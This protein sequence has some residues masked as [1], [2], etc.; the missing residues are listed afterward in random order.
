MNAERLKA[1]CETKR[2]AG[3]RLDVKKFSETVDY[4]EFSGVATTP[5]QDLVGDIVDPLGAE[6][7]LPVTLLSKHDAHKPIGE[8]YFAR[9][10]KEGIPYRARIPKVT[11]EGLVKQRIEEA[12]HEVK[13]GLVKNVS[14]GFKAIHE[15]VEA[16]KNGGLHF[17]RWKWLELSLAPIPANDEATILAFKSLN[18]KIRAALGTSE[19]S[20]EQLADPSRAREQRSK[21]T[22]MRGI[23]ELSARRDEVAGR[24]KDLLDACGGERAELEATEVAELDECKKEL[25]DLDVAIDDQR[26][27][28]RATKGGGAAPVSTVRDQDAGSRSRQGV[29]REAKK[30]EDPARKGIAFAQYVRVMYHAK[31]SPILAQQLVKSPKW[32]R[33]LDDRVP[34]LIKAAVEA[35][36]VTGT[37]SDGN[38]GME[39]VGDETGAVA[40]FAEFL[41]KQTLLG[42]FGTNGIPA[43]RRVPFRVPLLTQGTGA[44]AS[45]VG[46]GKPK[47]LTKLG[48]SRTTL[49][50]RKIA[51]IA[52]VTKE[53]LAD[54]SPA[55][56]T[57]LRDELAAAVVERSDIDFIDPSVTETTDVRPAAITQGITPVEATGTG[58]AD[59]VRADIR[60][61]LGAFMTAK[62]P[63]RS[64]VWIMNSAQAIA[65]GLMT[66][67]LG[68]MEFPGVDMNGGRLLGI[69]VLVTDHMPTT[70]SGHY[71]VLLNTTDV[72][73]NDDGGVTIDTSEHASLEMDDAPT[74]DSVTPT[75]TTLVSM[76]QT[77]S[78]AFRA[79]RRLNY[80]R[81]RDSGVYVI[82][83]ANWGEA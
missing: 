1:L 4:F 76:F 20:V 12:I 51:V 48:W 5:K 33:S 75:E 11:E 56:D 24:V 34:R 67:A 65:L 81:R 32:A 68:Q 8:V 49:E 29:A 58:D 22:N 7:S 74:H 38:W 78:V 42:K 66:N 72:Y 39:L 45:W 50:P 63:P 62:N 80:K 2:S 10:T 21:G 36:S 17:K 57:M 47:P 53:L 64:A 79:E 30:D 19:K 23:Q 18:T 69:P 54:S 25:G 16:L 14:I 52:A 83:N 37:G 73:F 13:Y 3:V 26:A 44:T 61:A 82:A 70:T 6:F 71:I 28:E 46:E 35:G 43:L 77:N 40:D 15:F 27:M 9:V 31:G 41:R 59:D 55:A 60:A